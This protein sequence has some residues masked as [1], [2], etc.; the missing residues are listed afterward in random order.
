[1]PGRRHRAVAHPI[2]WR[3]RRPVRGA[4]RLR[5]V[6]EAIGPDRARRVA[7]SHRCAYARPDLGPGLAR[8]RADPRTLRDRCAGDPPARQYRAT[9]EAIAD[10][11][12]LGTGYGTYPDA[13]K[14]YN[15]PDTGTYFLDKAHNTYLQVIM[16][17][18]WPAAAALY[19]GLAL[20]VVR[21]VR[22]RPYQTRLAPYPAVLAGCSVLVA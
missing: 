20:L 2:A 9:W 6:V 8:G 21:S 18:G 13:F 10:R 19:A 7:Q 12:L 5:V 22:S 17:L 1:M 14:A 4:G 15:R 16:E 11:P 3:L